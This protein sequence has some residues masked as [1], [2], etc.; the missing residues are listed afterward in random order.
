M[1]QSI[2]GQTWERQQTRHKWNKR[3]TR[4]INRTFDYFLS[5][6]WILSAVSRWPADVDVEKGCH[7]YFPFPYRSHVICINHR[8]CAVFFGDC[9]LFLFPT[10]GPT[11][12]F[13]FFFIESTFGCLKHS[14]LAQ[15][16]NRKKRGFEK[17]R[18]VHYLDLM[19]CYSKSKR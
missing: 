12:F 5:V 19:F 15:D 13:F 2:A 10:A 9:F 8:L 14:G 17:E 3:A 7:R 16:K 4:S 6:Y 11:V 1:R 18:E